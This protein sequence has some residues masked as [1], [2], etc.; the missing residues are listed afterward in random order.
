[1]Q[2]SGLV[3]NFNQQKKNTP[4]ETVQ[5]CWFNE[6]LSSI[7]YRLLFQMLVEYPKVLRQINSKQI[8]IW[9]DTL[10]NKIKTKRVESYS[11]FIWVNV[12]I[13]FFLFQR[14]WEAINILH[15]TWR[16]L[17]LFTCQKY[18]WNISKEECFGHF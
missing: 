10:R 2:I 15:I 7:Y 9:Y 14:V 12:K 3:L 1:M 4:V 18:Y 17:N 11:K 6:N 13:Y 16:L 5:M 8:K